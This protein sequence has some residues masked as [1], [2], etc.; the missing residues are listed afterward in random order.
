MFGSL[1]VTALQ[2]RAH[3]RTAFVHSLDSILDDAR[4]A[5]VNCDLLVLPEATFPA[6]VIG[7]LPV[8]EAEIRSAVERL[9]DIAAAAKCVIVAGTV[10]QANGRLRNG[11]LV[12]DADGSLV[13]RTDKLFLWH[14]DRHWFDAGDRVEPVTTSA[15]RLGVL[16]CADGRLPTIARTL[17]DRGAE[18]LVMPTAWVTSGRDPNALEN[19]QADLL[20]R[21]RAFENRV[22]FVA[23]NK[24]GSELGMVAYCGKSQIV[25]S[26]GEILAI[27][28]EREPGRVNASIALAGERPRR[29]RVEHPPAPARCTVPLRLAIS[30]EPLPTDIDERL[31]LLDDAYAIAPNDPARAAALARAVPVASV[32]D[33]VVA[34]PGG[35]VPYRR[36]GYGLICWS[37]GIGEP[38][39]VRLARARALELRLFLVVFDAALRRA[40]A[41]DPD[42]TIVA[43]T[44]DGFRIAS[45]LF[46]PRKVMETSVAPGTD[47]AAGLERIEA[48]AADARR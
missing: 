37:T 47:I 29:T 33:D 43:G 2:L 11:A 38:W 30:Y 7:R 41:V 12:I 6:Y 22:P 1:R 20:A 36:A 39:S 14:F 16:I 24:C 8:E 40:F 21:V 31:E 4:R 25:D 26:T 9:R 46:D 34:D 23:A 3:D 45:F 18:I 10:A 44:F 35:L 48:I 28:G 5:S 42:G 13:G 15:G 17:V 19:V 27:A 32:D